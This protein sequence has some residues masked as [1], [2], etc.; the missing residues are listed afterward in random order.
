LGAILIKIEVLP[1]IEFRPLNFR[2][3]FLATKP[4]AVIGGTTILSAQ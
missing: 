1:V 3:H 4:A 2:A